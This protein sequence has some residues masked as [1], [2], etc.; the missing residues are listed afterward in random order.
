MKTMIQNIHPDYVR[1]TF[2]DMTKM[3]G[4]KS[5][6]DQQ[7]SGVSRPETHRAALWRTGQKRESRATYKR[8]RISANFYN[9]VEKNFLNNFRFPL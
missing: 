9:S 2:E 1:T 5:W 6:N 8:K 4:F 7:R 3:A